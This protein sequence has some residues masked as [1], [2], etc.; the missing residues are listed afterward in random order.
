MNRSWEGGSSLDQFCGSQFWNAA[1][2]DSA[3][4]D[5]T[6]CFHQ[7]VLV[8]VPCVL[9]WT[10]A[11]LY[12]RRLRTHSKVV[13][14][15]MSR[16]H[17]AKITLTAL[18]LLLTLVDLLTA[19]SELTSHGDIP[20]VRIVRPL[21]LA[22]TMALAGTLLQ[23]EAE[24]GVPSSGLLFTF[25]LLTSLCGTV[26]ARSQIR[27][28]VMQE[29]VEDQF[30]SM[31]FWLYFIMTVMQ[32][33][34]STVSDVTGFTRDQTRSPEE[35][36]S[37]LSRI[38]FW[39]FT[40]LLML[41]YKRPLKSTDL[42]PLKEEDTSQQLVPKFYHLWRK[43][44]SSS[45][46]VPSK[47]GFK[48]PPKDEGD[49]SKGKA[50]TV[51]LFTA[52]FRCFWPLVTVTALF[53]TVTIILGL[54]APQILKLLMG[55]TKDK[56]EHQW[57]GYLYT[58]LLAALSVVYCL[59]DTQFHKRCK[60]LNLRLKTVL[61]SAVYKKSLTV[62]SEARKTFTVGSITNLMSVDVQ[63]VADT[64]YDLQFAWSVPFRMAGS[65]YCL[66]N[67]LGMTAALSGAT[68]CVL[69]FPFYSW[70]VSKMKELERT[71]M[72][73][74]DSRIKLMNE[75]LN[76]IKVL[77]LYAWEL[78][79][80]A[81]IDDIRAKELKAIQRLGYTHAGL[82]FTWNV[83][84]PLVSFAIFAA[85]VLSD[86]KNVLDAEIA[87][88][89][90][91]LMEGLQF[92]FA[93]LP[94]LYNNIL[95]AKVSLSRIEDFLGQDELN[96]DN[97][98]RAEPGPPISVQD[99][100]FSWGSKEEPILKDINLSIPEGALVAVIGQIGS[101]K[102]SLLSALLGE[103]EKTNGRVSVKG[104]TAYVSQQPWI[105]NATLRDNIL[106]DSP[107]NRCRY[108]EVLD[109]CALGPDL[110]MLSGGDLTE[111]GEKG[112]NLSG[113]QKQRVSLARAVYSGADVYYL[114]DPL[115]AVDPHVGRHIFDHVVGPN[116]LLK[117]KTRLLVTHGT[118]F[119][120]QC[121]RV[122]VLQDG[123]IW[124]MGDFKTLVDQ[125][126]EF[127]EYI[128]TYTNMAEGES[129]TNM[130]E[131]E[132][133]TNG[134][135]RRLQGESKDLGQDQNGGQDQS[136]QTPV[137]EQ[138]KESKLMQEEEDDD[139]GGLGGIKLSVLRDYIKSFG[140]GLFTCLCLLNCGHLIANKYS[141]IWLSDWTND[142]AT[143]DTLSINRNYL[144]LGGY[145]ALGLMQGRAC[146]LL[147]HVCVS[148][149]A[150][151]AA[152]RVHDKALHHLLRGPLQ[153]FDVTPLGRIINRF[154]QEVERVDRGIGGMIMHG[155]FCVLLSFS[156]LFIVSFST[157]LFVVMLL[158][159]AH[160]YFYMQRYFN[161]TIQQ[162]RRFQSKSSTLIHTHFSETLQGVSTI[163]A[164][165]RCTQFVQQNRARV[166]EHQTAFHSSGNAELWLKVG[167]DM[168]GSAATLFAALFVVLGRESLSPGTVG[169]SISSVLHIDGI[170][171]AII[172]IIGRMERNMVAFMR[173]EEYA[174]T[175]AEA[176]WIV[177]DHRPPDHWPT[178]GK[179]SLSSYQTRYREGLD[180]VI[181]D[182]TVN[183]NSGEK[184]GIVGRTGAGKSSLVLALF[185]IIEAAGGEIVI[186]GVNI[187]DIG[188]H[189]LRSRITVI[190]QDPV[191]FSGTL[192]VNL[193]PFEKHTDAEI[194]RA[195][196]LSHLKDF[197]T[198]LDKQLDH[199]V[200]E[201]GTNLSVGQRQLVCLARALLRKSKLLV[202]DEATASVDPE[203]DALIQATIRAQFADCTVLTIA[204]RLNTIMDS[205][206]ILVLD[207]GK[208]AEFDTPENLIS[209]KGIFS[210]MVQDAGLAKAEC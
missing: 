9:L 45:Q 11:P 79:F 197:V 158:P 154:S 57:K 164:F 66:W 36:S 138:R 111:I 118:S 14:S 199:Q 69:L 4:P 107:M 23:Y 7:T 192:R 71:L 43:D 24:R 144:L 178:E 157:P 38:T 27:Q 106:F 142:S 2:L 105:Q 187:S 101:G 5:V 205:T 151:L 21:H 143:N 40:P 29:S 89:V 50:G 172:H 90:H 82:A 185:R 102:S 39:W 78:S 124:L 148:E 54:A 209:S 152:K 123:R 77:K 188:L 167:L 61:T 84:T 93:V 159:I 48:V 94:H 58:A 56:E 156:T 67:V 136:Q 126:R 3:D 186:D 22:L 99:G 165:N 85:Y 132:S 203:T 26:T 59:A 174:E 202:L 114:D 92:A 175:P 18:M 184:I 13:R 44:L 176:D 177:E 51:S 146:A 16:I 8:W 83:T 75:V 76:G 145:A 80:K 32:L 210:S 17:L 161:A 15:D 194:W 128:R 121:D 97:V 119:L 53:Q 130:A 10:G 65:L 149:G 42:Y 141:V 193:D 183:I 112:I 190:P 162:L 55:F 28:A 110:E 25:W 19:V 52:L 179:I 208:V 20:A 206:R 12:L 135:R 33:I 117:N 195:L 150:V 155:I 31:M 108:D 74:K 198:G 133:Y 166:D 81:K 1:L 41:G 88:V 127:A 68:A 37:F 180:L 91:S 196:D 160:L 125:N 109:S 137:E 98:Q 86:E 46:D 173:M 163:R 6:S 201:G 62:T 189:D 47:E 70:M 100:T 122:I 64:C 168:A 63:R 129:Y 95:Q 207:G 115:S 170:L 104:S 182:I 113:G 140:V 181:K 60:T 131:G 200:S 87:F 96:P 147:K 153:F 139:I 134:L 171:T 49:P 116:G 120:P 72:E 35:S 34:L 103:M 169:L 30:R 191:V 204:H 73:H